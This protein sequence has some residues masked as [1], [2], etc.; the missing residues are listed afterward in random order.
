MVTFAHADARHD[1]YRH[2]HGKTLPIQLVSVHTYRVAREFTDC[3]N[4][5]AVRELKCYPFWKS[6][7]VVAAF[8]VVCDA[9]IGWKF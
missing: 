5:I 8:S 3:E 6:W 2:G 7:T 9:T 1:S 4:L